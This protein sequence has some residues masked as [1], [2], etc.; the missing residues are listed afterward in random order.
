MSMHALELWSVLLTSTII[1]TKRYCR[2]GGWEQESI[3]IELSRVF[4][5]LTQL[6]DLLTQSYRRTTIDARRR[7]SLRISFLRSYTGRV[8]PL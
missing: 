8:Y 1:S 6:I 4:A 3:V 2:T 5:D 7:A